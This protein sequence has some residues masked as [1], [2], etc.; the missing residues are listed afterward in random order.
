[1]EP[2]LSGRSRPTHLAAVISRFG[3]VCG[4]AAAL[5]CSPDRAA[6]AVG[7]EHINAGARGSEP[8]AALYFVN[9]DRFSSESGYVLPFTESATGPHAGLFRGS[10]TF[11]ALASTPDY[12]GPAFGH[13]APGA[14]LEL[15]VESLTGP[16]GGSFGFW[17]SED[18]EE[19]SAVT[20]EISAGS[21]DGTNRF[22]LSE[23]AGAPG[24]DP[25]GHVH[26]RVFTV[27]KPGFYVLGV[28][29]IDT[30]TL[31][32]NGEPL[33]PPSEL[34][35]MNLQAGVSLARIEIVTDA[36]EPTMRVSF[37]ALTGGTYQLEQA[38]ELRAG[39]EWVPVGDPVPGDDRMKEI[40]VPLRSGS[41]FF[42]LRRE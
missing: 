40:T 18:G 42:R 3:G 13:A 9:G 28:R 16:P 19:G 37:A 4:L 22:R 23:T 21:T 35:Q 41:A 17:E 38:S 27:N 39:A 29:I 33:H 2:R 11:T 15:V 6:A 1:M 31:G 10:I 12:G 32:P 34:F 36:D 26:G 24:D 7:H 8:G 5:L 20:F 30:S 25:Y 14:H